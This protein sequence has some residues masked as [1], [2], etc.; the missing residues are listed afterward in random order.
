MIESNRIYKTGIIFVH[1]PENGHH[2]CGKHCPF[3]LF[4]KLD[5][6]IPV[7]PS[8]EEILSFLRFVQL[9]GRVQICGAG[10]PLYNFEKNKDYLLHIIDV[11]HKAGY[12]VQI[13]TKY[14]EVVAEYLETDLSVVDM[15]LFSVECKDTAILSLIDKITKAGKNVRITKVA[16]FS[17]N[18]SEINWDL[19]DDY[20]KFYSQVEQK[21]R[22]KICFRPNYNFTYLDSD[23]ECARRRAEQIGEKYNCYVYMH[24]QSCHI[25]IPQLWNGRLVPCGETAK[26][27]YED[28]GLEFTGFGNYDN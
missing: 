14:T 23:V 4:D 22:F 26:Y 10:D 11:I 7:K 15:W 27:I 19:L 20:V 9:S 6:N 3:C 17:S 1:F 12:S 24:A 8:D 18:L 2:G 28:M 5:Y 13:V 16:N 25:T 21:Y